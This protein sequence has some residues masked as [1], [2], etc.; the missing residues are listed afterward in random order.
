MQSYH[1]RTHPHLEALRELDSG[2]DAEGHVGDRAGAY[3]ANVTE[4]VAT[5]VFL[6]VL[7]RTSHLHQT[8]RVILPNTAVKV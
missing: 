5:Q 4:N 3:S 1:V 2:C 6:E 8:A 7:L